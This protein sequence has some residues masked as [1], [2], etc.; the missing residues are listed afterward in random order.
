VIGPFRVGDQPADPLDLTVERP[1]DSAPL[2]GITTATVSL[3][4]PSGATASWTGTITG[5][6]VRSTLP[7]GTLNEA[8]QYKVRLLLTGTGG[9]T[10]RTSWAYF[11]VRP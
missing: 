7:A 8:G 11:R 10:E 5:N 3:L 2:S 1:D 9:V 6:V 4:K